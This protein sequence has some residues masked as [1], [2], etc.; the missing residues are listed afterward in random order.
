[1]WCTASDHPLAKRKFLRIEDLKD[2]KFVLFKDSF[3]LHDVVYNLFKEN[4]ITPH[5]LHETEHLT[6]IYAMLK[7]R[8][9]TGFL[10]H[11]VSD[12]F[13]DLKL[14]PVKP[15]LLATISLVWLPQ[16]NMSSDT[17]L[18]IDYYKSSSEQ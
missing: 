4:G 5:V 11:S 18:L 14:V 2:E 15:R 13:P 17:R 16:H 9:A 12:Y 7:K 8:L 1:M 3:L 10:M 6:M